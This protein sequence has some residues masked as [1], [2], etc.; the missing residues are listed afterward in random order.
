[1]GTKKEMK[2]LCLMFSGTLCTIIDIPYPNGC[3]KYLCAVCPG[4]VDI[5]I[6]E[7]NLS[8]Q[9]AENNKKRYEFLF[10]PP[11]PSYQIQLGR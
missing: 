11:T 1:M 3:K 5:N 9:R 4:N 2:S 7:R 10:G 8:P 6:Q